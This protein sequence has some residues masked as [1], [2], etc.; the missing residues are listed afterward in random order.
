[1]PWSIIAAACFESTPSGIFTSFSAG[2][3]RASA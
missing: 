3:L 1:M 2:T